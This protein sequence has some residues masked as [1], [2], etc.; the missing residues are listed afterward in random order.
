LTSSCCSRN[1]DDE[2]IKSSD[3]EVQ[4]G[5]GVTRKNILNRSSE[6]NKEEIAGRFHSISQIFI[7]GGGNTSDC[8]ATKGGET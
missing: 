3:K 6:L 8:K 2:A 7:N 4:E 5:F 1:G